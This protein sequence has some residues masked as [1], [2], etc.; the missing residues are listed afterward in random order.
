MRITVEMLLR[1]VAC[2]KQIKLFKRTF[3]KTKHPNG[4][5]VTIKGCRA[6]AEKFQWRWAA[7]KLFTAR[8]QKHFFARVMKHDKWFWQEIDAATIKAG[9]KFPFAHYSGH[10]YNYLNSLKNPLRKELRLRTAEAFAR[11]AN[12]K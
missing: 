7:R 12:V 5:L 9:V 11:A 6:V 2:N 8:Q 1:H 4:V 10:Y 3:P